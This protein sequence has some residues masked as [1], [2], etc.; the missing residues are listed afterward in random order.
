MDSDVERNCNAC[1]N[2]IDSGHLCAL[3]QSL[4]GNSVD[5]NWNVILSM[6]EHEEGIELIGGRERTSRQ[7]WLEL[8][9]FHGLD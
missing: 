8:P 7:R 1:D 4:V 6:S 5:E 3:C 9:M 2:K